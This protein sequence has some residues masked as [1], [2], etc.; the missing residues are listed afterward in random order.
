[1]PLSINWR[2]AF[3]ISHLTRALLTDIANL[4]DGSRDF[5]QAHYLSTR[6]QDTPFWRANKY[7]LILSGNIKQKLESYDDRTS[8]STATA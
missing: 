8:I 1:M 2:G 7:G 4:F 5:I 6:R 3:P